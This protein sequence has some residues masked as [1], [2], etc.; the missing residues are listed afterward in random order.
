MDFAN[1]EKNLCDV[2]KEE[3]IKLGYRREVIRLYY[4]LSSL[5]NLLHCS[6]SIEEMTSALN[7]FSDYVSERLG[8]ILISNRGERFCLACDEKAAEYVNTH[9]D[10]HGFLYD[11][12]ALVSSHDASIEKITELFRKYSEHVHVEK[13][14]LE[15]F[16]Y[17]IYTDDLKPDDYIYCLKDEGCHITYH[18]F[19]RD[20]FDDLGFKL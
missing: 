2:I 15:D 5:N 13:S 12:I 20:D 7:Q 17:V 8:K 16:D 4:P 11:F 3:E 10:S 14:H 18:R 19:S 9:T 1:L 6:C